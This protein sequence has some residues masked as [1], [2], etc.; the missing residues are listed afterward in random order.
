MEESKQESKEAKQE[1]T[2]V[3]KSNVNSKTIINEILYWVG[4]VVFAFLLAGFMNRFVI[5]NAVVPSGSMEDTIQV[6]D[7]LVGGRFSYL[8]SEPKRGDV[9]IFKY[10]VDESRNFIKRIIGLPG[11]HIE[12]I[13]AKIYIDGSD[14][15]LKEDYIKEEWLVMNDDLSYDVPEDCYFMLGDNR[16]NSAD[17]RYWAQEAFSLGMVTN[18]E[19]AYDYT[20]VH[21]DK[22]LGKAYFVYF[23]HFKWIE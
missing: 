23:N 16:N 19:D 1:S 3:D 7:R 6:K 22:I 9:V 20:Y 11:E 5:I 8:M 4:V 10:P 12:I 17:S 2:K 21:K 18:M 13:D 14:K 15:P